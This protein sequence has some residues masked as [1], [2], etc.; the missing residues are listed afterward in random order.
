MC[1]AQ[2]SADG[3]I[4]DPA[5]ALIDTES[6][7]WVF[8]MNED[9][10]KDKLRRDLDEAMSSGAGPKAARFALAVLS[11][12]VPIAGG[13]V[14]GASEVWS[15]REEEY[16][17]G[18]LRK[19][20]QL[21]E[22]EIKEIG[23]TLY[24]VMVRLDQTDEAIRDRIESPEYLGIVKKCFRNWSAAESEEK[25]ILIR[26]LLANA[27]AT[28]LT[29]DDVIRLFVEWIEKYSEAHFKVIREIYQH[30]GITRGSIWRNIH[31][32]TGREDSAEADLF[33]LIMHD[34]SVGHIA[35]QHREVDYHGKFKPP[36]RKKHRKGQS[37]GYVSAFDD[38][39]QYELTELG[40]QFVHYTMNEVVVK[41]G[42]DRAREN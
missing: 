1:S 24:E 18:I 3:A 27:A 10:D 35:R 20:L 42:H 36:P 32:K 38:E 25:R 15:E 14:S 39:K 11:G 28:K 23:I 29:S 33:K 19:W 5:A 12:L 17:K 8:V 9:V 13:I 6:P 7:F 34:L 2:E 21:Q 4:G 37:R 26:N 16:F 30:E 40:K 31:E 41:L 22:D